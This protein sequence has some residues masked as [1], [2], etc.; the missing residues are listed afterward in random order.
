MGERTGDESAPQLTNEGRGR[1]E[2]AALLGP[3]LDR[4]T[5]EA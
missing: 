1:R 3:P 5:I 2:V 4:A